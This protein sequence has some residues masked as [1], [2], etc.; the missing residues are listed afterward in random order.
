MKKNNLITDILAT[1]IYDFDMKARDVWV[2]QTKMEI[3]E[4]H[5]PHFENIWSD[6][7]RRRS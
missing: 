3:K 1:N 7:V 6:L 4:T 2:Y 5:P